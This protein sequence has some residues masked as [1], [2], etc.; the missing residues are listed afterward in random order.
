MKDSFEIRDELNPALWDKNVLKKDVRLG[1][2]RIANE[3]NKFCKVTN[4][5]VDIIFLGSSVN[6]NWS[7]Y[8][9]L[10][11]HITYDYSAFDNDPKVADAYLISRKNQWYLEHNIQGK[12]YDVE[13]YAQD[14]KKKNVSN[15]I[16][17]ILKN[18]WIKK[19]EKI[20]G[21]IKWDAVQQIVD[22]ID[23]KITE[24]V[25]SQDP[26]KIKNLIE[27][28]KKLRQE[29]LT[30]YGEFGSVNVAYKILRREKIME[31]LWDAEVVVLDKQLTFEHREKQ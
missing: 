14:Y 17:S 18:K 24:A 1:L 21:T 5:P 11:V 20:T 30:K 25:K 31:K 10:D 23:K 8:S 29:S 16:Y 9:D 15:G 26:V 3:F 13:L 22:T 27:K 19:P 28:I 2:L 12:G 6:Y 4:S 7:D